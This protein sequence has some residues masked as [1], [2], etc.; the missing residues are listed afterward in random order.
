LPRTKVGGLRSAASRDVV[1]DREIALPDEKQDKFQF[2]SRNASYLLS[3]RRR[4]IERGPDGEIIETAPRSKQDTP[5]DWVRFENFYFET[6]DPELADL[7][8]AK[9][10]FALPSEGGEFWDLRDEKI[11]QDKAYEEELRRRIS[12]RPDIAERV[13]RPGKTEDFSVPQVS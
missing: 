6:D 9:P 10:G 13:L 5:L 8:R 2:R 7:I 12:E 3:L 1:E 4:R 11:A